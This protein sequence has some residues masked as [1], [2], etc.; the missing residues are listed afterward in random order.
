MPFIHGPY[1]TNHSQTVYNKS[2]LKQI[3][4]I[5]QVIAGRQGAKVFNLSIIP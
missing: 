4:L 3:R 5:F 2:K 1:S